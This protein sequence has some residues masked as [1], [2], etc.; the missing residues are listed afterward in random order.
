MIV[1]IDPALFLSQNA[2]GPLLPEEER[3]LG[4]ALDDL[5][6][7]CKDRQA[8]IP[9]AQWY[10]NEL[11]RDL[12]GP[13]FA[14]AKPGSRLRNGL[15]RLRDHARAVP[16]LDKPIQGTTK[17]WGVKPLFDW[18]RLPTKW[19]EIME[20][21]VIGC[22]QQRDEAILV[23]RLFAGRN[24]NMHVV[25]RCTL[26]EKTRWQ[27]QVH[28]P[29]HTPR[30]IRCV[31][32][33]RNVTIA[34]TTRL[35][36]KLPDTGHFPFCPPANW[37]RRDTQACRTFESKPAWI[38]RF[39]SGWSQPA[40]GGYYHWDVFLDEPNLQQSVGLNQLNIVAWGTAEPGMVP[41]EIHHVPKE[42][43]AHLREGAG[44]ACPKGV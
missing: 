33:L 11:Q 4:M 8:V 17:I 28:V 3:D 12:I 1:M 27:I 31:R 29:G 34:W 9:N 18:P 22:A 26:A 38:D 25:G 23:T 37:W 40:T 13:L 39:G 2:R 21:L 30:R 44:W 6:R 15:D 35:D 24:L 10:W 41:G 19:L 36:E 5:H 20:R 7:I 14:R 32:S 42:K 43:K 16:L